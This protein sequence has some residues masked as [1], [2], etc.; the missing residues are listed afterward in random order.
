V[1]LAGVGSEPPT[2][3]ESTIGTPPDC[4][5]LKARIGKLTVTGPSALKKGKAATYRA[6]ITNSGN[7]AATGVRLVVSGRGIRLS[8][9][10]GRINAGAT[11][12]V[13]LRVRPSRTGRIKATFKATS[14]NA[15]SRT[16]R[17]TV[18]VR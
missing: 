15:G 7:A 12:T 13:K 4:V 11:R 14:G 2:C 6:K 10:V 8:S 5:A 17:K 18:R 9:P 16:V 1:D 3:P